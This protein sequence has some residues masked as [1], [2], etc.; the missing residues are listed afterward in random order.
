MTRDLGLGSGA[1]RA[2]RLSQPKMRADFFGPDPAYHEA[3]QRVP[4]KI[5]TL[6]ANLASLVRL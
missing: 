5:F 3:R 4:Q 2:I 1:S 6:P